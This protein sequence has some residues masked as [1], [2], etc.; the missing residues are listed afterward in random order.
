MTAA[1]CKTT[2]EVANLRI[3]AESAIIRIKIFRILKS[4]LPITIYIT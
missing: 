4:I 2:K 1:E 3:H